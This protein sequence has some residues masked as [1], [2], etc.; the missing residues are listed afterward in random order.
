VG[1]LNEV[2][3]FDVVVRFGGFV[4]IRKFVVFGGFFVFDAF[5]WFGEIVGFVGFVLFGE[6]VVFG[7]FLCLL[8]LLGSVGVLILVNLF[9]FVMKYNFGMKFLKKKTLRKNQEDLLASCY[10][11]N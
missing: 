8:D 9:I 6:L 10:C 3:V 11:R 2:G 1:L 7:G 4:G 5:V